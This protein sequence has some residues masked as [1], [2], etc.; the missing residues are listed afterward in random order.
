MKQVDYEI[1][2]SKNDC[3]DKCILHGHDPFKK[4][5][6]V[7][8]CLIDE[9]KPKTFLE[10]G[11][12][13]GEGT[14]IICNANKDMKVYSLDLPYALSNMSK[15]SPVSSGKGETVGKMCKFPYTQ[16]WGDSMVF[17]YPVCEG[18]FI[19]GEHDYKHPRHE[20]KA[21]IEQEAEL[22]IWHDADIQEVYDAITDCFVWNKDYELFRVTG[23]AIAFALRKT[24][25]AL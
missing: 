13:I 1:F 17:P 24:P 6:F 16:L 25:V 14:N 7:L 9:Y 4:D 3:I 2:E 22:I 11:T 5:Y 15:Q 23:T 20:T 21:A 19:D 12:H 8:H 10:V 18:W